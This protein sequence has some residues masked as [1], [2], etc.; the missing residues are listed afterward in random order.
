[1]I[2]RLTGDS[3]LAINAADE[4]PDTGMQIIGFGEDIGGLHRGEV[5]MKKGTYDP[6][7]GRV[8]P[9]NWEWMYKETDASQFN[10][11]F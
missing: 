2:L 4:D 3:Y 9:R 5:A 7:L 10:N 8:D 6:P 11:Q 1:M